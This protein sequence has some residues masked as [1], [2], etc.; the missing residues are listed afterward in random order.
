ME[1]WDSVDRVVGEIIKIHRSLLVRPEIDEVV[2]TKDLVM[3][4]E[5]MTKL[6]WNL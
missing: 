3:N 6:S 1:C 4:I 5:K 2:A